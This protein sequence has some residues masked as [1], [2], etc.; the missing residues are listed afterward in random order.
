MTYAL[1]ERLYSPVYGTRPAE[2]A[3]PFVC[4]PAQ[5]ENVE[6]LR[7]RRCRMIDPITLVLSRQ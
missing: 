6:I 1:P 7:E 4:G 5:L 2:L 3:L